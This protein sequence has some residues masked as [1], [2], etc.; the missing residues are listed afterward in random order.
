[1][2]PKYLWA[3][4][5]VGAVAIFFI[6]YWTGSKADRIRAR[7]A[8]IWR[9]SW[10]PDGGSGARRAALPADFA[11]L[12][13]EAGG[14]VPIAVLELVPKEAWLGVYAAGLFGGNDHITV[15]MR[16]YDPA[17][18]L[19]V[20]PLAH[21]DEG[22]APSLGVRFTKDPEF[23]ASFQV[24]GT[25]DRDIKQWLSPPVR[26]ELLELEDAFL[27]VEGK[28]AALSLY[29]RLDEDA[30][31]ALVAGADV[32]FAEHGSSD[33]S[34]LGSDLPPVRAAAPKAAVAPKASK[35]PGSAKPASAK[36][37]PPRA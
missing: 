13:D 30:L 15:F 9:A 14:G 2:D 32:I 20:A 8:E 7:V 31:D 29:T 34:L 18:R 25:S 11:L 23:T 6:L 21:T 28:R 1:M 33:A 24:D 27:R 10:G 12:L 22:R 5:P 3:V 4:G 36:L 19:T 16:L 37:S 35:K 17:P 26:E